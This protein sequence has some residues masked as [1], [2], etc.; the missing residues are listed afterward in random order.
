MATSFRIFSF[1]SAWLFYMATNSSAFSLVP[2][3]SMATNPRAF[4]PTS[5][6]LFHG[7]QHQELSPNQ[8]LH[9]ALMATN[10]RPF[11]P[12]SAWL[13]GGHTSSMG[14]SP[15]CAWLFDGYQF[16]VLFFKLVPGS[17]IWLTA[18]GPSLLQTI[19]SN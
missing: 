4:S 5:A 15:T 16:Q 9:G 1:K 18:P 10:S 13:F 7:Y 6:W 8:C 19:R 14:F 2:G 3:S 11:F 17:S 12:T